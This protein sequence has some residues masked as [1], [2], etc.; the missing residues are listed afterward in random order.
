MPTD[1]DLAQPFTHAL[2]TAIVVPGTRRHGP[3]RESTGSAPRCRRLVAEAE[4]LARARVRR[5]RR[6]QRLVACRRPDR[7][8]ADARHLERAAGRRA[9]HR[10]EG[11]DD[12]GERRAHAAAAR[13]ARRPSARSSSA[14]RCTSSAR[15]TSSAA[16]YEEA[17]IVTE[18]SVVRVAPSPSALALGARGDVGAPQAAAHGQGR[19]PE[20]E[21]RMSDTVVFIPAWNEED[22]L[23]AVLDELREELPDADVLVVDDGSTDGTAGGRPRARRRGALVRGEPRPARGDRRRLRA[24]RSTTATPTAAASTR[25]VSIRPP[26]SRDCSRS[27]AP[28]RATSRSALASSPAA[29][30]RRIATGRAARAASAQRC[31]R[32]SMA[33]VLRRPFADATSGLYAVNAKALPV[34]AKPVHD[35]RARGRGADPRRRRRPPPRGSAGEHVATARAASR[36]CAAA[37]P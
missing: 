6:L 13:R 18:L 28:T 30:T 32:R 7:G 24:G 17:G 23:P 10:A 2:T 11:A 20:P 16:L 8:G 22:N 36:S 14:R 19:S 31:C 1:A 5:R 4:R 3:R 26:S 25:T 33:L 35:R 9:R 21:P 12:G 29:T 34:L 37:R 27:S 15:A